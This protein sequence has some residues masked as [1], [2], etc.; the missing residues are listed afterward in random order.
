MVAR[1]FHPRAPQEESPR[2]KGVRCSLQTLTAPP[3]AHLPQPGS[4]G[5]RTVG[6]EFRE[7]L[8][9]AYLS[10]FCSPDENSS[11]VI[12]Q[13]QVPHRERAAYGLLLPPWACGRPLPAL[14]H[15]LLQPSRRLAVRPSRPTPSPA[16]GPSPHHWPRHLHG[17]CFTA[18][19]G[20]RPR[21]PELSYQ[22]PANH[23]QPHLHTCSHWVMQISLLGQSDP[24]SRNQAEC[25][26]GRS[27]AVGKPKGRGWRGL[28]VGVVSSG[29]SYP[30]GWAGRRGGLCGGGESRGGGAYSFGQEQ[31]AKCFSSWYTFFLLS[32]HVFCF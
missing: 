25:G 27:H 8:R 20:Q 30:V 4:T 15:R 13:L 9:P 23:L 18:T 10:V 28:G 21:S 17:S 1:F 2:E 31:T 16:L 11:K 19:E 22:P 29:P 5:L 3:P 24:S 12:L 7:R 32:F 6:E 14:P 26:R